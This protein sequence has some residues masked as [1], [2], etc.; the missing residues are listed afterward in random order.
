MILALSTDSISFMKV[1]YVYFLLFACVIVLV[2]IP[3]VIFPKAMNILSSSII[4]SYLL[5]FCVGLFSYTSLM[6]ILLRVVKNATLSGYMKT[7][8]SYI[9][10]IKGMYIH[11]G[12]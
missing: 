1:N 3:A 6:E 7:E 4:G 5:I 8:A 11:V 12:I 9:F 2:L 10:G